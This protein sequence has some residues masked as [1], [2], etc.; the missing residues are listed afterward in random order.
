MVYRWEANTRGAISNLKESAATT[1]ILPLPCGIWCFHYGK[2]GRSTAHVWCWHD[3]GGPNRCSANR[4]DA[5]SR[6]V[7]GSATEQPYLPL[8]TTGPHNFLPV[9]LRLLLLRYQALQG[10]C[11]WPIALWKVSLGLF[12]WVRWFAKSMRGRCTTRQS[13]MSMLS[14]AS[15]P[16]GVGCR[17]LT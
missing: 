7:N 3:V 14:V 16:F 6:N 10:D 9:R 5:P 12:S 4:G 11:K 15:A 13:G 2:V 17:W 8:Q 1:A